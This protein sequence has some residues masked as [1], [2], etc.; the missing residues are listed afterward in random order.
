MMV[1]VG[2]CELLLQV[3]KAIS[4]ANTQI[5]MT[6]PVVFRDA[7]FPDGDWRVARLFEEGNRRRVASETGVEY[8]IL[9][10]DMEIIAGDEYR[11]IFGC[12]I[13]QEPLVIQLARGSLQGSAHGKQLFP[14]HF[15]Y[16]HNKR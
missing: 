15:S 8:L 6:D 10:G 9:M 1:T 11:E 12:Q 2:P 3:S 4:N 16:Y 7:A 5:E 13:Q 14:V